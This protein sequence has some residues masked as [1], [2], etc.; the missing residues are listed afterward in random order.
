MSD[1]AVSGARASTHDRSASD[2]AALQTVREAIAANPFLA[3]D[4]S[5]PPAEPVDV[6]VPIHNAADDVVRAGVVV[7]EG[8]ALSD[9]DR[10]LERRHAARGDG[11]RRR[12]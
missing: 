11:D 7:H 5:C 9:V 2:A 3:G 12:T 10:D 1:V 8:D 6:I 4:H